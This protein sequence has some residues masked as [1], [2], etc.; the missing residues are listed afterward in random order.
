MI[1]KYDTLNRK[2]LVFESEIQNNTSQPQWNVILLQISNLCGNPP[3]TDNPLLFEIIDGNDLLAFVEVYVFF[4][5]L[6]LTK[7]INKSIVIFKRYLLSIQI[8]F[9]YKG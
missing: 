1:Y 8:F 3:K 7:L 6:F 9:K 2:L 5:K 4:K